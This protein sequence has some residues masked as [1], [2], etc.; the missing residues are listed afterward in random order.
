LSPP[1]ELIVSEPGVD[2]ERRQGRKRLLALSIKPNKLSSI[3]NFHPLPPLPYLGVTR[4]G[5]QLSPGNPFKYL[6][7]LLNSDLSSELLRYSS[8]TNNVNVG[9]GKH[10]TQ[11]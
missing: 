8:L 9:G 4:N 1:Q 11:A 6:I 2:S 3:H 7:S 5:I 10:K